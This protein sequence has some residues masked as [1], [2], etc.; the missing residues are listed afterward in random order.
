MSRLQS[1]SIWA[2][3]FLQIRFRFA[4]IIKYNKYIIIT[5]NLFK[6]FHR[7]DPLSKLSDLHMRSANLKVQQMQCTQV[8]CIKRSLKNEKEQKSRKYEFYF[9]NTH[10]HPHFRY[11]SLIEI[12]TR[13]RKFSTKNEVYVNMEK[14]DW[15]IQIGILYVILI[16][17]SSRWCEFW[18]SIFNYH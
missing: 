10:I 5:I 12:K 18:T 14:D 13:I 11:N 3:S 16:P 4:W 1:P 9:E 8:L 7:L 15:C 2:T 17:K 6:S